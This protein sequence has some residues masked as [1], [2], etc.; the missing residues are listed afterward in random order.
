MCRI[1]PTFSGARPGPFWPIRLRSGRSSANTA[2]FALLLI[3]WIADIQSNGRQ[4]ER[5]VQDKLFWSVWWH[6]VGLTRRPE[7]PMAKASVGRT[8]AP[9]SAERRRE[10]K[11]R[12]P[13]TYGAG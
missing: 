10:R 13:S 11:V 12:A 7:I 3:G 2:W 6:V 5:H 9:A 8:A 1:P 4:P